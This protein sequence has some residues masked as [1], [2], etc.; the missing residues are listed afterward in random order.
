MRAD[1]VDPCQPRAAHAAC[2]GARLHRNPSG[3]RQGTMRTRAAGS[4]ISCS[5][6]ATRMT[7]LIEDLLSL[8]R[9]E[10]NAHIRP[11]EHHRPGTG[12]APR[13]SSIL[14]PLARDSGHGG[15]RACSRTRAH[16]GDRVIWDELVQVFQNL[17]ENAMKYGQLRQARGDRGYNCPDLPRHAG[18]MPVADDVKVR[19]NGPGIAPEHLPRLTETILQGRH[20]R[21]AARKGGTGL[22]LAIVKHIV[23]RH[24]GRLMI[25]SDAGPKAAGSPYACRASS[26]SALEK[27]RSAV[28]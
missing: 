26:A 3:R 10:L 2:S 14:A 5:T 13:A 15:R 8:S 9:I 4:W 12:R 18:S 27:P 7:R 22:G 11:D 21:K 16:P 19:D 25:D 17:I 24:R 6:Q 28:S 20:W 23:N 1:F